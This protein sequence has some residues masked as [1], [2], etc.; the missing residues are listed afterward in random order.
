MA[1]DHYVSQVHLRKFYSPKLGNRMYAIRKQDLKAFTPDASSVCRIEEGNTNPFLSE[2][3]VIEEFL[4]TVEPAYNSSVEK[5]L[6]DKIDGDCIYVIAGFVAYVLTCS[7]TA[8]RLHSAPMKHMIE[9]T[10][11]ALDSTD[12]FPK[13]PAELASKSF[14]E[15]LDSGLIGVKVDP[16]Y[17][18]AVGTTSIIELINS[19][20]NFK[21]E[22]LLNTIEDIPFFTSDFPV[23]IEKTANILILNRIVPLTPTLAI[24]ICPNFPSREETDFSFKSFRRVIRCL[25]RREVMYINRLLVQCAEETVFFRDNY[26]WIPRFVEKNARFQL[27][28]KTVT[29][30]PLR[31]FSHEIQDCSKG[32]IDNRDKTHMS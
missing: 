15:L 26:D 24:R 6:S 14:T 30:G 20:G 3:R 18:Q 19:Y 28:L 32:I 1:L 16:K 23:A 4:K 21:W 27:E 8:M 7:P 22:I 10:G 13:A 25:T 2:A 17:P 9:E 31:C 11:R 5:L 12:N 29:M